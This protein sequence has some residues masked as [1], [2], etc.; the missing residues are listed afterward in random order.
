MF[1]KDKKEKLGQ[2]KDNLINYLN[3]DY[4][5]SKESAIEVEKQAVTGKIW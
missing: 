2:N 1:K 3:K 4:G 5:Y